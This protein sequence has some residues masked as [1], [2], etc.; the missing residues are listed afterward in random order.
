MRRIRKNKLLKL[1]TLIGC[2]S[3]GIIYV[4]I[5]VIAML[6][7]LKLKKGGADESSLFVFLNDFVAGRI[8]N[9]L[10]IAGAVCF[11]IW[12]FYEAIKDP[13]K[14]GNDT[15]GIML[16]AGAAFSSVADVFVAFSVFQALFS[17]QKALETGEPVQ[18]REM[19][20]RWFENDWGPTLAATIAILVLTTA[21]VLAFY[22]LSKHFTEAINVKDFSKGQKTATHI[23]AYAGYLSRAIILGIVGY[24][25][26]AAALTL[27]SNKVVNTDKAFD[28]IG[29]H[30]GHVYFIIVAAGTICYGIY[31]F[32]LGVHYDIDADKKQLS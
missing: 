31:M 28:F 10:I 11:I 14:V 16:R 21:L 9:W 12:R 5:G 2:F 13:Y 29:D 19:V 30:V 1:I 3:T 27:D 6:S 25:F 15:K 8:L 26:F 17:K 4:G 24:S 32:V 23:I 7:F 20:A 18:Q 22:G